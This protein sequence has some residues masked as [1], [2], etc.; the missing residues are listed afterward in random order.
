MP[1]LLLTTKA[2]YL[3]VPPGANPTAQL[4]INCA[5]ASNAVLRVPAI[6]DPPGALFLRMGKSRSVAFGA[7]ISASKA[8]IVP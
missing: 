4:A 3:A 1:Q 8:H 5:K 6:V 7:A 2:L